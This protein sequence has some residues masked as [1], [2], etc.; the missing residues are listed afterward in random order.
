[1]TLEVGDAIPQALTDTV[2]DAR[3]RVLYFMRT[4]DCP[5]CREHVRRLGQLAPR[6]AALGASIEIFSPDPLAPS[7][8]ASAPFPVHSG[9]GPHA[10]AGF[11]RTLG[12]IQQSGT[13]V[14]SAAGRLLLVRRATLPFQA[15]DE[16]ELLGLLE[17][18]QPQVA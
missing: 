6:L 1:M 10:L 5:V 15:F 8:A 9:A 3:Y 14:V 2:S 4:A 12:A 18:Q 17:Q 7:W 16:R 13:L 11:G